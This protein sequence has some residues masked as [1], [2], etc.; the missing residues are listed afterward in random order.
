[1]SC[2]G[3]TLW[4][5]RRSARR[6]RVTINRLPNDRHTFKKR[7]CRPEAVNMGTAKFTLIGGLVQT[8]LMVCLSNLTSTF[9]VISWPPF[10]FFIFQSM[11]ESVGLYWTIPTTFYSFTT[12]PVRHTLLTISAVLGGTGIFNSTFWELTCLL[13]LAINFTFTEREVED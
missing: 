13:K 8:L 3:P 10:T 11:H 12:R 1:M 6:P 4:S 5:D 9:K 2:N 7:T